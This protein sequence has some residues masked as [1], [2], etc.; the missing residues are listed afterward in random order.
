MNNS[1]KPVVAILT[2]FH[3][4]NPGY[5]LTGIVID[6]I[7]MLID[8]GHEVHL[9]V[10][11]GFESKSLEYLNSKLQFDFINVH[12][13]IKKT[14]LKDYVSMI[15]WSEEH[16]Y[17]SIQTGESIIE[18][19]DKYKINVAFTHDWIFTGWN[20][21]YAGAIRYTSNNRPHVAWMHWVHSVPSAMRDWWNFDIYGKQHR[22]IFPNRTDIPLV[23]ANYRTS[24]SNVLHIPHIKD[25]RTWF[26]MSKETCEFVKDNP[27]IL[28]AD[29]VQIYPCGTDRLTAK[30]LDHIIGIFSSFKNKYKKSVF[31]VFANQWATGR[32][33]REELELWNK[34]IEEKGLTKEEVIFTSQYK[35]EYESG[36][37]SRMIRELQ[38]FS[39]MFIFPT[40]E[41][42]F[43]LVGPEACM[44]GVFPVWNKSLSMMSGIYNWEGS[45]Y[46]FGSFN[47]D[48]NINISL[49]EYHDIVAGVILFDL[50]KEKSLKLKTLVRQKF[51][52]EKIY[53]YYALAMIALTK[54]AEKIVVPSEVMEEMNQWLNALT[55][56]NERKEMENKNDTKS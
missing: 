25:L 44:S 19:F 14:N 28:K 11:E 16:Q 38:H 27:L 2:N 54:V 39:N 23:S 30:G 10:R 1:T 26:E 32:G 31:L 53:M 22:I 43:G 8:H 47:N 52:F 42:S 35:K 41:E 33:R 50:S 51:N 49:K 36:I 6:Q 7:K 37:S 45:Y 20:L 21:P 48:F 15:N 56:W 17:Y 12:Q 55:A 4:L 29:I 24:T 40:R 5:S 18:L 34:K 13:V 46:D 3:F 9:I